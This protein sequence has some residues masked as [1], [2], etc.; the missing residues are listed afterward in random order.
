M[1]LMSDSVQVRLRLY[2]NKADTH[3]KSPDPFCGNI[4]EAVAAFVACIINND[5]IGTLTL[6]QSLN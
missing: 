6:A 3:G 1:E 4:L 2:H 5:V